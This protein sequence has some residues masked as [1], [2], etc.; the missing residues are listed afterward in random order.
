[1]LS[2]TNS[3]SV[4]QLC[5]T[6]CDPMDCSTPWFHVLHYLPEF[7]QTHVHWVD[8]VIQ[9]SHTLSRLLLLPSVS[10]SI[11]VFTIPMADSYWD[12][13]ETAK[14]CKAIILQLKKKKTTIWSEWGATSHQSEWPSL[15][16]INNKCWRGCGERGNPTFPPPVSG[17][18]SW[19]SH[20]GKQY[21]GSSELPCDPAVPLMSTYPDKTII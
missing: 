18:V 5:L 4:I 21:G 7:A 11:R 8:D 9:P 14:F 1:M 20:S 6:L 10:P 12:L 13:T 17:N 19:C 15:K 3:C 2:I 16:S